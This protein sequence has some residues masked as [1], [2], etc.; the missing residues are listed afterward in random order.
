VSSD[1]PSVPRPAPS[2]WSS[3]LQ[4]DG[5]ARPLIIAHRG[6]SFHAPE[7]TLEAARLARA[8]GADAWELDVHLTRDGAPVVLHDESL[9]RTT[10]VAQRFAGD[11]RSA[12]GFQVADFDL[13]EVRTL[14][15]GSWFVDPAGGRRSAAH[16]GTSD[17]VAGAARAGFTSG[18]VRVPTLAEALRLTAEL[19]WLVN[20]EVKSFPTTPG[21]L[22][23]AVLELVAATGTAGRVLIS[24]FD[25][26]EIARCVR[27]PLGRGLATGVLAL[28]PLDRPERY[29]R[30]EVGALAYHPSAEVLGAGSNAYRRAPASHTLRHD[31]LAA[32]RAR[33]VPVLVFTVNDAR[34]DGLAAH[35]AAAGVD[36]LFSD[37]PRGLVALLV[38]GTS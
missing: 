9:L 6:D 7:N 1:E 2:G 26:A 19:D 8:A 22:L 29:V 27:H 36:A 10:D 5:R 17:R 16:F 12:G 34:P 37:D 33:G 13:V 21:G 18:S 20:V 11:P 15:A 25:H 24:S 3:A 32:L 30:D 23:G 14:D 38:Q 35:L 4:R 31:D 28:T